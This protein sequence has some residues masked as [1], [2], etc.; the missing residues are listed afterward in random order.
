VSLSIG[1]MS[2]EEVIAAKEAGFTLDEIRVLAGLGESP[3]ASAPVKAAKPPKANSFYAEV[4][5]A[6]V[7][8][9]MGP[10]GQPVKGC[11]RHFAPNGVGSKKHFH[12]RAK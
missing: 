1:S 8:C 3:T 9:A 2:I 7:P 11:K 12:P 4:I 10:K 6:R 5:A